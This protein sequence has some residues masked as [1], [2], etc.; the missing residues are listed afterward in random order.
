M[1]SSE[2]QDQ[3]EV[4]DPQ[5]TPAGVASIK[6]PQPPEPAIRPRPHGHPTQRVEDD[7][8]GDDRVGPVGHRSLRETFDQIVADL[9]SLELPAY[10][11]YALEPGDGRPIL[12]FGPTRETAQELTIGLSANPRR[13]RTRT[14]ESWPTC[15]AK[16]IDD[17][18][19]IMGC[20]RRLKDPARPDVAFVL[21]WKLDEESPPEC[22]FANCT[23]TDLF[24]EIEKRLIEPSAEEGPVPRVCGDAGKVL[25]AL[26]DSTDARD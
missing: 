18:K 17:W 24:R 3:F 11:F 14:A 15:A 16:R 1:M 5:S 25:S 10:V 6:Q 26:P 4:T 22:D 20:L 21:G 13:R 2:L 19:T 8:D 23:A 9:E 7:D 12:R